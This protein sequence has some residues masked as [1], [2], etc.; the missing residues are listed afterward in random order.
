MQR[1]ITQYLQET[2]PFIPAPMGSP[3][4]YPRVSGRTPK[5]NHLF[6]SFSANPKSDLMIEKERRVSS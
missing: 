3:K 1:S 5:E 6:T 4:D 2:V